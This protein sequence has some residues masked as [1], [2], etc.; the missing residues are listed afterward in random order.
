MGTIYFFYEKA[1][2]P[3]PDYLNQLSP[4]HSS[5]VHRLTA[6]T[7]YGGTIFPLDS[8]YPFC[9]GYR[10]G[11]EKIWQISVRFIYAAQISYC[12]CVCQSDSMHQAIT[13]YRSMLLINIVQFVLQNK[14]PIINSPLHGISLGKTDVQMDLGILVDS[15]RLQSV[16][17][18][19]SHGMHHKKPTCPNV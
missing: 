4:S 7:F 13:S 19:H 10:P 18:S 9:H 11:Y 17:G 15:K 8:L 2:R 14:N 16:P 6:L 5:Q 1:S 12:G 3:L